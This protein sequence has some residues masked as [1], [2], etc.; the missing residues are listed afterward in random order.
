MKTYKI[1]D[2]ESDHVLETGLTKE[3]AEEIL[4]EYKQDDIDAGAESDDFYEII[5]ESMDNIQ[6]S[7]N[8]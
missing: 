1:Y 3:K 8:I 4:K 7:E 6:E 2:K 5:E